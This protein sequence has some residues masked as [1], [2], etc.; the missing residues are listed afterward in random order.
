MRVCWISDYPLKGSSFGTVTYE[1]LTRMP[2]EHFFDV[3]SLAYKGMPLKIEENIRIFELEKAYQLTYYFEK[4]K[5]DVIVLFHSYWL[6][7]SVA[8][9]MNTAP[10]KKILYI[11]VEGEDVPFEYRKHFGTYD[12]ILTPSEYSRRVLKKADIDAKVVPHGV[13]TKFFFPKQKGWHE[14]RF[15]YLG[16]NDIRKQVPRVMEAYARLKQG[17]L[18]IAADKE[19]HY[20][21]PYLAKQYNI[22]PIFIEQKLNGLTMSREAVRDFLQS[23]DVYIAPASEC[24]SPDTEIV[25]EEGKKKISQIRVGEKV[26][27]SKGW[28][29]VERIFHQENLKPACKLTTSLLNEVASF[30]KDHLVLAAKR[31]AYHGKKKAGKV[32]YYPVGSLKRG[33][34]VAYPIPQGEKELTI[35]VDKIVAPSKGRNQYTTFLYKRE[36]QLPPILK[37]DKDFMSFL[38]YYISEGCVDRRNGLILSNSDPHILKEME[39]LGKKIFGI[40]PRKNVHQKGSY[41]PVTNL[42]FQSI[43]LVKLFRNLFG[44]RSYEKHLPWSFLQLK[45]EYLKAFLL[46]YIKGDGCFSKKGNRKSIRISTTS[47]ELF[48]QLKLICLKLGLVPSCHTRRFK[49]PR[50]HTEFSLSIHGPQVTYLGFPSPNKE[51]HQFFLRRGKLVLIPIKKIEDTSFNE[52]WDIRVEGTH[53]F[54]A[55]CLVHNSFGLPAL[56]AQACGVPTIAI[57]HGAAKEVLNNGAVYCNVAD[58]LETTIGKIALISVPDLY[59]KMRFMIQVK[60]AYEKTARKAL[61]NAQRWPWENAVTKMLEALEEVK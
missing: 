50:W 30:T 16:L 44:A 2:K 14:F 8:S 11:P 3:L 52:R 21:L 48:E 6:L 33:D 47:K 1:L 35:N 4:L 24:L 26:L 12:L 59:R 34:F 9:Q 7:D 45:N 32:R 15:G 5:P 36:K 58:Y 49:N 27:T 25:T 17:T 20:D 19:G 41:K 53:D 23:L 31:T 10:G 18:V 57:D 37:V 39:D 55:N 29:R 51:K 61:E 38:G 43:R 22:A 54:V 56:E 42:C 28:R 46:T 60:E 40:E 13:D